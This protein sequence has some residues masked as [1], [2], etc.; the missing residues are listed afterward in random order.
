MDLE[1]TSEEEAFRARVRS[2]LEAN[3]PRVDAREMSLEQGRLWQRALHEAGL[4]GA[5]WPREHGGAGLSQM[6]QA[7]LNEELT[8]AGT[9][10]VPGTMGILWVGPAI[11]K[12]GSEAQ[13]KR[14][15]ARILSGDDLWAT[16]YSEPNAGSD[17]FNTQTRAERD[18][19]QY[20]VNGQKIW[21]THAHIANWFFCL[22][23]VPR[24]D[25]STKYD[26]LTV[27]L[28]DMTVP[29]FEVK[30]IRQINGTSEFNEVF[31][32]DVRVPVENRLGEE[33]EGWKIVSSALIDERSGIASGLR[34]ERTLEH[35]VELARQHGRS[36]DP[37]W[38]QRI[39][40]LA[41]ATRITRYSGYRSTTDAVHGR[42]NPHLSAAMKLYGTT[43]SQRF[44]DAMM[45]VLGP[46]A[47]LFEP[48]EQA[49]KAGRVAERYLAERS[50]TI[51]G[52]TS[53][54]QKNIIAERILG[55]PRR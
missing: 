49:P 41:I 43:L 22:V 47:Q 19:D 21:T 37:T 15:V 44:A 20:V 8:R 42:L 31:M 2:F 5:A 36:G 14:F 51:A 24:P 23:R 6:E 3:A 27:L 38:R 55:L 9:P 12:Y 30:P 13:K 45:D 46:Y 50:L 33:D 52:G 1:Y 25:A 18:G 17:M 53:E 40:D 28:M 32:T 48:H 7:I 39:A 26:G 54:I 10:P 35:L 16:G 29:G 11:L 34:F 4:L